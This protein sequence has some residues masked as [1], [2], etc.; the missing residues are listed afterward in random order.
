MK[1]FLTV[2]SS[3]VYVMLAL[4][5][6]VG[7]WILMA[8]FDQLLFFSPV[9]A[10]YIPSDVWVSFALST[11]TSIL[12]GIILSMNVYVFRT[13]KVKVGTSSL[14]SGSTLGII[15][16]ACAGCT[17]AGFFLVTTFGIAGVTAI[18][19]LAQYQMP[20]RLASIGL[21]VWA[22]YSVHK[23]IAQSCNIK[24]DGAKLGEKDEAKEQ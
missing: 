24:L 13:S 5:V 4:A 1:A 2:F 6:A 11:M 15:S 20:L 17:S 3:K 21:L 19:M 12:L 10:F 22:Y 18:S 14:F 16:G 9:P 8:Q 23:R 7:F